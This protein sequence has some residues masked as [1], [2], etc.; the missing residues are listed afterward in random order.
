MTGTIRV[1]DEFRNMLTACLERV[2]AGKAERMVWST[3]RGEIDKHAGL[4][5]YLKRHPITVVESDAPVPTGQI[6]PRIGGHIFFQK[7]A[8]ALGL[9][10]IPDDACVIKTR[11]DKAQIRF[12]SCLKALEGVTPEARQ[13]ERIHPTLDV[14][15]ERLFTFDAR[16]D[17]LFYWDD[18][19]YSGR[20]SDLRRMMT[21]N[22][23]YELLFTVNSFPAETRFFATPFIET[24]PV[25]RDFF[26]RINHR[27]FA[28]FLAKWAGN[29]ASGDLF[30]PSGFVR[31]LAAHFSVL[32]SQVLLPRAPEGIP[33]VSGETRFEALFKPNP[34]LGII[35]FA[36]PWPTHKF[37]DERAIRFIFHEGALVGKEAERFRGACE[38]L[39]RGTPES[40][41]PF[42]NNELEEIADCEKRTGLEL[43]TRSVDVM[44][45]H[46]NVSEAEVGFPAIIVPEVTPRLDWFGRK[47]L[48]LKKQRRKFGIAYRVWKNA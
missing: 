35:D 8:L 9:H 41:A 36:I 7:K 25:F 6:D 31:L 26:L 34:N 43:L 17:F 20:C 21:M 11:T 16:P 1:A 47:V 28:V 48:W 5:D 38:E 3:W 22:C 14:F 33:P 2:R 19:V 29:A 15:R 37:T 13:S 44:V 27:A 42:T 46:D 45:G 10:A 24:C 4:R 12:E 23:E 30:L 40:V 32:H 39:R 18:I